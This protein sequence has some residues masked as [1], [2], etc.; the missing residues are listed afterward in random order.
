MGADGQTPPSPPSSHPLSCPV[1]ETTTWPLVNS[2]F[3][4]STGSTT[5]T[6]S[7]ASDYSAICLIDGKEKVIV[8]QERQIENKLYT[9][10]KPKGPRYKIISEIRSTPEDKFQP[11]RITKTVLLREKIQRGNVII[12]ENTLRVIIPQSNGEIPLFIVYRALGKIM[13]F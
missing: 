11:A 12:N 10:I 6:K 1:Q 8:A 4:C 2:C 3:S 7:E 5:W 9:N 13:I